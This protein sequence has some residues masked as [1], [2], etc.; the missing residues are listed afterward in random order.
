MV[1]HERP[2]ADPFET[3]TSMCD[4]HRHEH[5]VVGEMTTVAAV[6]LGALVGAPLRYHIDRLVQTRHSSVFPWGTLVVNLLGCFV[7]G[8][9]GAFLQAGVVAPDS[10]TYA[11]IGTGLCGT[12]TTYS[13]FGYETLR[14]LE[15]RASLHALANVMISVLAGLGAASV[16]YG[17][18]TGIMSL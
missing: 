2:T 17:L 8:G 11:L 18:M 10:F 12:L 9:L 4:L 6:V 15:D 16:G 3:G 5:R 7:F 1:R 14:L 13:T